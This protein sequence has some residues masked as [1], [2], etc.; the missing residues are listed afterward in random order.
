M[1]FS[2]E[3]W[4]Y[5]C[6]SLQAKLCN[7]FGFVFFLIAFH[8]RGKEKDTKRIFWRWGGRHFV[9][10][11]ALRHQRCFSIH[12]FHNSGTKIMEHWKKL[13]AQVACFVLFVLMY[14]IMYFG[15]SDSIVTNKKNLKSIGVRDGMGGQ[16]QYRW[17]G[18]VSAV[19]LPKVRFSAFWKICIRCFFGWLGQKNWYSLI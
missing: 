4:V 6:V 17:A 1:W 7:V 3:V 2:V 9:E 19:P 18:A 16:G 14:E 11:D 8:G 15:K 13:R 10:R 5:T 12:E